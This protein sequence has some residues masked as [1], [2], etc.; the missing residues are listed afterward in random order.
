[1]E[2]SLLISGIDVFC[3][4]LS[5]EIM[6]A[7]ISHSKEEISLFFD[8]QLNDY[9]KNNIARHGQI[10]TLLH[11]NIP[12]DFY[13]IYEHLSL[14]IDSKLQK[15]SEISDLVQ[16]GKRFT[17]LGQA[18]SG[19]STLVKHLHLNSIHSQ[20]FIPVTIEFRSLKKSHLNLHDYITSQIISENNNTFSS[21]VINKLM[22]AGKL[23]VFLD[24]F[25]EVKTDMISPV[26]ESVKKL[27][28]R[29]QNC[30]YIMTSRPNSCLE[31]FEDFVNCSVAPLSSQDMINFVK[32]QYFNQLDQRQIHLLESIKNADANK[33]I[34]SFLKNPLLL[35]LYILVYEKYSNI[36][37]KRTEFYSRVID[38]LLSQH[39]GN[40]KPGFLRERLTSLSQDMFE[41]LL[42]EYC[43][44]ATGKN[45]Y[46][47]ERNSIKSILIS[48]EQEK[49]RLR[50]D[51]NSLIHDLTVGT[52]LWINEAAR[53]TFS[54]RSLQ[55]YF[56]ALKICKSPNPQKLAFYKEIIETDIINRSG[57]LDNILS[58]C[59]E[60][61]QYDLAKNY[62]IPY[63]R[64]FHSVMFDNRSDFQ[65]LS[66]IALFKFRSITFSKD[67]N[68]A[69]LHPSFE[70]R[71]EKVARWPIAEDLFN[72]NRLMIR[73]IVH[74]GMSLKLFSDFYGKEASIHQV[75]AIA[76]DCISSDLM[77]EIRKLEEKILKELERYNDIIKAKEEFPLCLSKFKTSS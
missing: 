38:A 70:S 35:T 20:A 57:L 17:I 5:L 33:E 67:G 40:S 66:D 48:I 75:V 3:K 25:D 71:L 27:I 7:G 54:H 11:G 69:L 77:P 36:P 4:L 41:E 62:L 47:F 76:K 65:I 59:C 53:F 24:G 1:M 21:R 68:E 13:K 45:E 29:F 51:C 14:N 15:I 61:D 73:S 6:K 37:E 64:K 52:S 9:F 10:K 23:V 31:M 55:E 30:V 2:L 34:S 46:E 74:K 44:N 28:C 22:E 60:L 50:V 42:E 56:C 58:M 72:L 16:Y 26:L 49:P 18:G 32:K 43:W 8:K 39:D 63:L 19:K 12:V